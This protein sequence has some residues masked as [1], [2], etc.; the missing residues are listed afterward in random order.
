MHFGKVSNR[1]FEEIDAGSKAF[2]YQALK[3]ASEL[4]AARRDLIVPATSGVPAL[5]HATLQH[6]T[7]Q[8][9]WLLIAFIAVSTMRPTA[10]ELAVSPPPTGASPRLPCLPSI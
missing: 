1:H 7:L 6:A 4:C 9:A 5:Q 2:P 3:K 10:T 8:H